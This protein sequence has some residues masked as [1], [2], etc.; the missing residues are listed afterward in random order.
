MYLGDDG[1][2]GDV[3]RG[4]AVFVARADLKLRLPSGYEGNDQVVRETLI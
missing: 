2:D 1:A 3:A 4:V